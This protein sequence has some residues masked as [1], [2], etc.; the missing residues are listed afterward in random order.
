M[1]R[2]S[3]IADLAEALGKSED[4]IR[5]FL[6]ALWQHLPLAI[7]VD[8]PFVRYLDVKIEGVRSTL[9]AEING[10]RMMM[11]QGFRRTEER[12]QALRREMEQGFLQARER[13]E[14][15]RREINERFEALRREMDERFKAL[16]REMER[17]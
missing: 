7:D 3:L 10:L 14:E 4:E 6:E 1:H 5:Q 9:E 17:G 12:D 11:E 2:R 15:L 16:R 8:P 13:D